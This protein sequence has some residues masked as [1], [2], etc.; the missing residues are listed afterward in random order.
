MTTLIAVASLLIAC[1]AAY[2]SAKAFVDAKRPVL[3]FER[4]AGREWIVR[5]VGN[6]PALNVVF[7]EGDF[8]GKW[9]DPFKLP[10]VSKNALLRFPELTA[11]GR[12]GV[13]YTDFDGRLYSSD[14]TYYIT[15]IRR[16]RKPSDWPSF[17]PKK[18]R[19]YDWPR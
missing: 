15:K 1:W 9:L 14:C 7:I 13:T 11:A 19:Y 3:V 4:E 10:S 18:I 12:L 17:D 5:N 6:G 8:E 2:T 16:K